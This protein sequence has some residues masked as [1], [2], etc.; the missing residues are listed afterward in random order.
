[1]TNEERILDSGFEDVI[2]LENFDYGEALIGV[3]NT[4]QA[5]YD[6]E[7]MVEWLMMNEEFTEEEA[8]EWIS[9]NT[10]R[11]LPYMGENHPL[12]LYPLIT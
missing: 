10:E 6:Y 3:T 8:R 4:N 12:I 11:A 2:C 7:K 9:Y 5:V 1:M